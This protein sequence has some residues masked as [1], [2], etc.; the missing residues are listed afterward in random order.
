M[1]GRPKVNAKSRC[2]QG[3]NGDCEAM[4]YRLCSL[5]QRSRPVRCSSPLAPPQ[6]DV[7]RKPCAPNGR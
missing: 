1:I 5:K 3:K 4:N 2:A 7:T 6:T